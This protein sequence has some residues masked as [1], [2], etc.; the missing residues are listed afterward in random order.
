M[1][2]LQSNWENREHQKYFWNVIV[3]QE[4]SHLGMRN[5]TIN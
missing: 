3:F 5:K 1:A 4:N 2:F